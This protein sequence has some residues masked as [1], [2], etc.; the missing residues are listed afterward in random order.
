[1]GSIKCFANKDIERKFSVPIN[2][3]YVWLHFQHCVIDQIPIVF[4]RRLNVFKL[5][6]CTAEYDMIMVQWSILYSDTVCTFPQSLQELTTLVQIIRWVSEKET[7]QIFLVPGTI[8][9]R[10]PPVLT[11][12]TRYILWI[13]K[14]IHHIMKHELF[15]FVSLKLRD[16]HEGM[17]MLGIY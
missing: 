13:L 4:C 5:Q 15:T 12:H 14:P 7:W 17:F 8:A 9:L 1:M 16:S 2:A 3:C 11:F 6:R 10:F